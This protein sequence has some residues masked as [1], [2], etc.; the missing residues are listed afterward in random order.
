MKQDH[1]RIKDQTNQSES[2][3]RTCEW[4][5]LLDGIIYHRLASAGNADTMHSAVGKLACSKESSFA[6]HSHEGP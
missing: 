2:H 3:R 1:N 4:C 6:A 5:E